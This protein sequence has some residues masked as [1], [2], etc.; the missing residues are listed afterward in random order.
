MSVAQALHGIVGASLTHLRANPAGVLHSEDPEYVHQMRVAI[1]RLRSALRLFP[2]HAAASLPLQ[3]RSG[4]RSLAAALGAVRDLDVFA[5]RIAEP[6]RRLR[7][8]DARGVRAAITARVRDAR[9]K[10]RKR[11]GSA[12]HERLVARLALWA[13]APP[14]EPGKVTLAALARHRLA[15]QHRAVTRGAACFADLEFAQRH[16]LRIDVKRA[17]YA[18][19]FFAGLFDGAA[20]GVYVATFAAAQDSLGSLTDIKTGG[21]ILR[22]FGFDAEIER[23]LLD[24]MIETAAGAEA[25]L[26]C[27]F[28]GCRHAGGYWKRH[29]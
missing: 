7:P 15:S 19:E 1:R 26:A 9:E 23:I 25:L 20:A 18:A 8:T 11:L 10:L 5:K 22:D 3:A 24:G 16:R 28:K 17:R 2:R 29:Q 4:L 12:A 14:R 21:A 13:A 6:L 27:A